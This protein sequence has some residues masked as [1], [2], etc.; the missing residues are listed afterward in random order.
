MSA[1]FELGTGMA[2]NS[3]PPERAAVHLRQALASLPQSFTQ[4]HLSR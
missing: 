4:R 1:G 2:V 3:V